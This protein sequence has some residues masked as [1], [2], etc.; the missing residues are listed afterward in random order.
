M[1]LVPRVR[2]ATSTASPGRPAAA[3]AGTGSARGRAA[4]WAVRGA[5]F[6]AGVLLTV[7]LAVGVAVA[8]RVALLIF[9]AILVGSAL[10]PL[11]TRL[12]SRIGIPRGAAILVVY[13]VFFASV[14]VVSLVILPGALQQ[15]GDLTSTLPK[16]LDSA[17]RTVSS[18]QPPALASSLTALVDA[19]DR[20]VQPGQPLPAGDIVAAG[21]TVAD[22]VFSVMTVLT[23]VYFWLTERPR[24]QRFALSFLPADR[25]AGVRVTWN[26]I[27]WRLGGWLRGQLILMGL[28]AVMAT[29]LYTIIGLPSA[30]LLGV[31]AGLAEVVPI[32]GPLIGAVPAVLTAVVL[33]PDL[34]PVVA[35]GYVAI[36]VI[37]G[38]VLVPLIMRNSVGIS[39]FLT[40]VCLLAGGA[41]GGFVGALV[42][43]PLTAATV[44]VLERLQDRR[45]PVVQEVAAEPAI[46][47]PAL[48]PDGDDDSD[49]VGSASAAGFNG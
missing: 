38:N 9:V 10:N 28:L 6:A 33:R 41:I 49:G 25:R 11:T 1:S 18:L 23:L 30:L 17:R 48:E 13:G 14:L 3:V 7:A 5:G 37:E 40:V 46:A 34:L 42:A 36:Q 22:I 39:P 32:V 4:R 43:V 44:V 20:A 21:L 45:V 24:L 2:R 19:A 35:V 15:V 47:P 16:A 31:I 12:R 27:E 8:W 29:A 26:A